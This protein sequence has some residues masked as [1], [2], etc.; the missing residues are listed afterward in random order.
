MKPIRNIGL[1][2]LFITLYSCNDAFMERYPL[3]SLT[4]F[5]YWKSESDLR[6]Y[7]NTLYNQLPYFTSGAQDDQSDNKVPSSYNSIAAGEY[8]VPANGGGWDFTYIRS[9]NYFLTR[10]QEVVCDQAI[11]NHYVGE[12]RLFRAY[13]YY[14]LVKRFGDV[15]WYGKEL[16][17]TS[18]EE[19]YKARD[20][21][22]LVVDSIMADLNFAIE[23]CLPKST[24]PQR[25][26]RDV[27][28]ALKAR[29]CLHEGTFRKYHN[30]D[31]YDI[32]LSD[33][34]A[35][36]NSLIVED[37]YQL[38]STGQ[39]ATDYYNY[40]GLLNAYSSNETILARPYLNSLNIGHQTPHGYQY[41]GIFNG[42]SRTF[43]ESYLCSDGKPISQSSVYDGTDYF[44][45]VENRDLRLK[46]S[47]ATPGFVWRDLP[48]ETIKYVEG[49][50]VIGYNGMQSTTGYPP[51]KFFTRNSSQDLDINDKGENDWVIFRLGEVL[52]IYAEAKA[53]LGECTQEIID[54]T[55][56]KLR[57]RAGMTHMIIADLI[58]DTQSD[59]E[60]AGISLPV[61]IE[62][63]RRERRIE[64]IM[65]EFRYDDLMRWA[66]GKMFLLPES[67][68]GLQA[69][70]V[71]SLV[72]EVDAGAFPVNSQGF[73]DVYKNSLP[74]GRKFDE[75]KNYL[76]PLPQDQLT[77]CPNLTQN[78][79]WQ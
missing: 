26:N 71:P 57:D 40:F 54:I 37:N 4:D 18:T 48:G 45:Q 9:C 47:I 36:A 17:T 25:F 27:A 64:L 29:I 75:N 61:L 53:E 43:F 32:F 22:N 72:P 49:D 21:R 12:I 10:Y 19:L 67:T 68:Q 69:T 1:L 55:I 60:K 7:C 44:T 59:F 50:P 79:G 62:E 34:A 70:L 51:V 30:L 74:A 39:P 41:I 65:E 5:T 35:A 23:N 52:L 3:D 66:A 78:P 33:A 38:Y 11:K 28:L 6:F 8:I 46:Q 77:L 13:F 20:P 42:L 31:N 73:I 63:I 24:M 15:P 56:N 76:F 2:L 16:T 58:K 14:N